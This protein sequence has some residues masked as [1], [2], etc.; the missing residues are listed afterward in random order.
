MLEE[1]MV[2][3]LLRHIQLEAAV[4]LAA[5]VI[6]H[7]AAQPAEQ[8]VLDDPHLYQVLKHIMQAAAAALFILAA[9]AVRAVVQLVVQGQ[10]QTAAMVVLELLIPEVVEVVE[11]V[12]EQVAPVDQVS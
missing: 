2:D 5:L 12:L 9:Q 4:V 1:V 8:E 11:V 7:L 6:T 10:A 3:L